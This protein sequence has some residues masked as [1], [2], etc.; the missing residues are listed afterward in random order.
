MATKKSYKRTHSATA[1]NLFVRNLLCE[2]SESLGG[3]SSKDWDEAKKFFGNSCAYTGVKGSKRKPLQKDHVVAHN[4][5]YGGLHLRGNIVPCCS[6]ANE[7]KLGK[8]LDE[9]F[10]S[11]APCLQHL[12]QEERERKKQRILEFQ[13][14]TKY[15][16]YIKVLPTDFLSILE[17]EYQNIQELANISADRLLE[18]IGKTEFGKEQI[19][20]AYTR[21]Y[22]RIYEWA[23]KPM[24]KSHQIVSLFLENLDKKLS[25]NDFIDLVTLEGITTNAY[26]SVH[27]MM[28][29]AG[30]SYGRIFMTDNDRLI[31][32]PELEADLPNIL[33]AYG[34]PK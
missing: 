20:E 29:D 33:E 19:R 27:S 32:I 10:A 31:L 22:Q 25:I 15:T 21:K 24:D 28:S 17:Q 23:K 18:Q 9:F 1:A 16:E 30:N 11:N 14:I 8:T 4:R 5:M 13:K 2:I 7:Q 6:E 3:F 26:G 12:S 34:L